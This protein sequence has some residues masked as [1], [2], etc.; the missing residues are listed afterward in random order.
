MLMNYAIISP[1]SPAGT[2]FTN[3]RKKESSPII[4]DPN[5]STS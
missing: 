4:R 3:G 5:S 1:I 2:P